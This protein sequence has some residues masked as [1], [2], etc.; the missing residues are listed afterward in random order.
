MQEE[1]INL[2]EELLNLPGHKRNANQ[3]Y[4]KISPSGRMAIIKNTSNN[5]DNNMG[6]R[7]PCIKCIIVGKDVK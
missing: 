2:P 1:L 5:V 6:K 7:E 4:T 3:N